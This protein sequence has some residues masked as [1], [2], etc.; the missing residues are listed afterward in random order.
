MNDKTID[1]TKHLIYCY[2]LE[3][4]IQSDAIPIK[5]ICYGKDLYEVTGRNG[6]HIF[7]NYVER[8]FCQFEKSFR[9]IEENLRRSTK[10]PLII[11]ELS[12][13]FFLG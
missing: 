12:Y 7:P 6:K 5:S 1:N 10:C 9:S 11:S 8:V 13:M 2:D 3:K 4:R